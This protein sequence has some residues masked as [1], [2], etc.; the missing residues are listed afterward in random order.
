MKVIATLP[1]K[2]SLE[3]K[4]YYD[5]ISEVCNEVGCYYI[6]ESNESDLYLAKRLAMRQLVTIEK[7]EDGFYKII[8]NVSNCQIK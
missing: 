3:E 1:K 8:I 6:I 4:Q 2:L 5:Y 7:D